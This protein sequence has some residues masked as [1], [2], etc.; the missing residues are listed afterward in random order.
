MPALTGFRRSEAKNRTRVGSD[1]G[2]P[3]GSPYLH[4]GVQKNGGLGDY[5]KSFFGGAKM[6]VFGVSGKPHGYWVKRGF[7]EKGR[8]LGK[9]VK[10]TVR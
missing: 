6:V 7:F 1:Q 8:F 9:V 10:R 5:K 3:A 4:V 2:S